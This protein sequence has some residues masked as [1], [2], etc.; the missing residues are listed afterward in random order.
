V[1]PVAPYEF[2]GDLGRPHSY[3]QA[4]EAV[5]ALGAIVIG[6]GARDPGSDSPMSHLREVARDSG[7]VDESG[8]PLAFDIG[9]TGSGVGSG[10]VQAVTRLAAGLP[11]DVDAVVEDVPGD[12]IDARTLVTRIVARSADPPGGVRAIE[13]GRFLGVVP[14]TRITFEIEVDASD[15]PPSPSTRRVPALIIFRAFGRSRLGREEVLIVIP[16]EDG[17]G[18]DGRS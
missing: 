14:W 5:R 2:S 17:G 10:I 8:S 9:G 4:V 6:L 18:C 1:S 7:A 12:E 16:G 15:L 3:E 11:L 13:G